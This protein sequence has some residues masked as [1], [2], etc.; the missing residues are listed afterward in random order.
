[1][2][3]FKD[4]TDGKLADEVTLKNVILISGA[5]KNN[6]VLAVNKTKRNSK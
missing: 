5:V 3:F 6:L 4:H 2:T 1:M